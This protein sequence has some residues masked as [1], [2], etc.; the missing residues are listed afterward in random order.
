MKGI[1]LSPIFLRKALA[2][3][4]KSGNKFPHS[5]GNSQVLAGKR[6]TT[7][8]RLLFLPRD[9]GR[10]QFS[11]NSQNFFAFGRSPEPLAGK[12]LTAFAPAA[13]RVGEENFSRRPLD[14]IS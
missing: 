2:G 7:S 14:M 4:G 12:R 1:F 5:K 10:R 3:M 8:F 13:I 11:G 6:V 9:S